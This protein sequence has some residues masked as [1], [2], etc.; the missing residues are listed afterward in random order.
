MEST[1]QQLKTA[2]ASL[3]TNIADMCANPKPSYSVEGQS[4]SFS[5]WLKELLDAAKDLLELITQLEP[6]EIRTVSG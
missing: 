4:F 2:L 1:L 6:Y 5:G 3:V